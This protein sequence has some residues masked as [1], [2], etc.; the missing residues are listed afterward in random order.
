MEVMRE[1]NHV[2]NNFD[3]MQKCR[4][5]IQLGKLGYKIVFIKQ[6]HLIF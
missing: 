2:S 1:K 5:Y 4:M 3:N 6:I